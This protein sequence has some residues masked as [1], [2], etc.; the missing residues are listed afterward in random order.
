M[1]LDKLNDCIIHPDRLSVQET[2][3]VT[4]GHRVSRSGGRAV[5]GVVHSVVTPITVSFTRTRTSGSDSDSLV[6][7]VESVGDYELPR[8]VVFWT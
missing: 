3:H 1:I 6:S 7:A 4:P 5:V 8:G 2:T